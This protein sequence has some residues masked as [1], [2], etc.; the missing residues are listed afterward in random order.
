LTTESVQN[1]STDYNDKQSEVVVI[2][3]Q[4]EAS[5]ECEVLNEVCL[6]PIEYYTTQNSMSH[7]KL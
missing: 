1:D 2:K 6:T 5:V 4:Q 3:D 7:L